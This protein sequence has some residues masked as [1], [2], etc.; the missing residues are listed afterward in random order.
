MVDR[1]LDEFAR[2]KLNALERRELRRSLVTTERFDG[3]RVRSH[4]RELISFSCNDYLGLSHR[5]D[6]VEASLEA[7]RRYGVGSGASRLITGNHALYAKLEERL[8]ALK[9]TEDSVVF[10]SGYL[11]NVGVIPL[12]AGEADLI[13]MDEFCHSCLRSGAA[14]SRAK[15]LRFAHN[16]PADAAAVLAA[17]R[18]RH[19]RC[20]LLTE[21]VFSMEG[22]LAP[23]PEL[24]ELAERF[25][26]WLMTDD[27]HGLGVVGDGRGSSFA[28]HEPVPVPLQMGTLSKAA[29]SY[30][31][32]VCASHDV[33][34]LIRN[35]ARSFGFS[36]GLPPG[37][38]A[39][40]ASALCIIATDKAL[41]RIPR[42]RARLF[43]ATLGL[44]PAES[45]VVPLELGSAA[46]TVEA[47]LMLREAGFLVAAI[48]PP[49][50][51]DGTSR[52]RFAFS[53]AH[54]E[55]DVLD[56][57]EAVEPILAGR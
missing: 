40:A 28:F 32:Y 51:P 54:S 7:T 33:C 26:A 15:T 47:S 50:V 11:T 46:R 37:T 22:D 13:I 5:S 23:L 44:E 38:V 53:A 31:G 55:R 2:R 52:L 24:C 45:A 12:L 34:E 18:G 10:G 17:R 48:R 9:D 21:G 29:G 49:T 36:T 39:A 43:T 41:V 57:A 3:R 1:S 6:V 56:L 4:G 25:D 20:V 42:S 35:R 19:R 16:D 30:G 27:A 8:A 14:L